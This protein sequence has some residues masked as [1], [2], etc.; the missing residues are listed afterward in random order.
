MKL[1][2]WIFGGTLVVFVLGA[3]TVFFGLG[4]YLSP[5]SS[6]SKADAIVAISGGETNARTDEAVKLYN[7][8]WSS[9][10]IFSGAALDPSS[11]SNARA[12]AVRAESEGVP[13]SAIQLDET[14][15]DTRQNA[16][17]TA[18]IARAGNYRS[19]ILVTSPYHQ[20]RADILFSRALPAGTAIV[21]HSAPDKSWR[22]SQ[23]WATS[24]SRELTIAELQKVIY[25]LVSGK[26]S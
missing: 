8:G 15:V 17:N 6:L 5:Q 19:I 9:R 26:P 18:A 7:E 20:R 23:W 24:A 22:R 2:A 10:L 16:A 3:A 14:A 1:L 12:M 13:A 11:P 4:F 25:E 21:N